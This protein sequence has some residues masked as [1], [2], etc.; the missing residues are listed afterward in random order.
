MIVR[1][2]DWWNTEEQLPWIKQAIIPE[3]WYANKKIPTDIPESSSTFSFIMTE[4]EKEAVAE[5]EANINTEESIIDPEVIPENSALGTYLGTYDVTGEAGVLTLLSP[6]R[7]PE[8]ITGVA[9]YHYNEEADEWSQIENAEVIDGYVWGTLEEF[10]PIAVFTFRKDTYLVKNDTGFKKDVFVCVGI[11]TRVYKDEEDKI[12]AEDGYGKKTELTEDTIIVGGTID[13]SSLNST[14]LYVGA[15]VKLFKIIG[16]SYCM[17]KDES[18]KNHVNSI[19]LVVEGCESTQAIT[20]AGVWCSA[21][22]VYIEATNVKAGGLG[23]QESYRQGMCSN[24][25]LDDAKLGFGSKQWVKH[26]KI[27]IKDSEIQVLYCAANNGMSYTKDAEI[28]VDGGTYEWYCTGQS[29]GR[30]DNST[31]KVSNAT[32]SYFNHN[33]RGSYG[34]G[35]SV[36]KACTITEGYVFCDPKEDDKECA[37]VTGKIAVDFDKDCVINDYCVGKISNV[38][39]VDNAT[40]KLYIDY[41]KVSRDTNITYTRN[42]EVILGDLLAIK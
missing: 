13:G 29:N 25:T 37:E 6:N 42:A 36:M 15:G 5:M 31:A 9:A 23:C 35:K 7:V 4:A 14:N 34:S 38:E 21:D 28:I 2:N 39:V 17:T 12:I 10:S 11:P 20:G 32:I 3:Y 18:F 16:G 1:N 19:K 30:V 33:N 8:E 26:S 22:E 41:V 27:V 24:V 40:A